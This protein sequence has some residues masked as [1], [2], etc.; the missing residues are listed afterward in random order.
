MPRYDFRCRACGDTFEV[1]PVVH[2]LKRGGAFAFLASHVGRV[3]GLP[4]GSV[5]LQE[6]LRPQA[7]SANP[8]ELRLDPDRPLVFNTEWVATPMTLTLRAGEARVVLQRD[9]TGRYELR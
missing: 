2:R 3:A 1:N 9:A 4:P 8:V 7:W 6:L 5:L